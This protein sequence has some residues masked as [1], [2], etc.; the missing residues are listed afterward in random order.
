LFAVRFISG[1]R[2]SSFKKTMFH[3]FGVRKKKNTSSCVVEKTR[4][5]QDLCGAFYFERTAKS[6]FVFFLPCALYKTYGKELLCH[7]PDI[8]RMAKILAHCKH[9]FSP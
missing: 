8:K 2:Q 3:F 9:R 1:A 5:K 6:F 4:S 7:T